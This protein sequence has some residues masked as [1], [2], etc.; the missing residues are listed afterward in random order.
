MPFELAREENL[1][2]KNKDNRVFMSRNYRPDSWPL[3]I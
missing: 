3:E 1:V 2:A